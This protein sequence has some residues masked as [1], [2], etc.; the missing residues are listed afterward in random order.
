[1]HAHRL[2][3]ARASARATS[4]LTWA[5]PVGSDAAWLSY[6]AAS[7]SLWVAM[8]VMVAIRSSGTRSADMVSIVVWRP[9]IGTRAFA[10]TVVSCPL[11]SPRVVATVFLIMVATC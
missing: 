8:S 1:M 11:L 9:W 10:Y 4:A 2:R 6:R 3:Y 7:S 5:G